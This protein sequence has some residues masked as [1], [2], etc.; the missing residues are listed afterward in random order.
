LRSEPWLIDVKGGKNMLNKVLIANRGEIAVRLVR[1]CHDLGVTAVAL[2]DASDRASLHVRLADECVQLHSALGYMDQAEVLRIARAVGA[3]AIHPGYGFLAEAPEF[4]AAC[5]LAGIA[6]VGPPSTTVAALQDKIATLDRAQDAGF[7]VPRHSPGAFEME[8][9]GRIRAEAERVGYPL[10]VKSYRGGRGRGTRL[11]RSPDRL[12]EAVRRSQTESQA[13][14]GDRQFYLEQAILPSRYVEVSLLCDV[15]GGIVHLGEHDASIQRNNHKIVEESPAPYLD[16]DQRRH[17]WQHAVT[18]ARLFGCQGACTVEF[19]MDADGQFFFTEIKPRIQ[20]EH[21]LSEMVT[22]IDVAREQIR[23]ADGAPLHIRQ[24]DIIPCGWA[25]H[26]RINA[27]DP[28]N[29]SLPSP[30]Q[31]Q[32]FRLPGG[33]GIRVDTYAYSGCDVPVRYDPLLAKLVVWDEDRAAC[34]RRA[35]RALE[36]FVVGGVQ[37]NLPLVQRILDDPDFVRGEYTTEFC[38][39]PLLAPRASGRDLRDLAVAAAVA[40]ASRNMAF[41]PTTLERLDTGWHRES[42]RLPQ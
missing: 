39:R 24:S 12:A 36:D 33:P 40:Y 21:P 7:R 1:A 3:E 14:F 20:V 34:L 26:C 38:R 17:L 4:I 6:F 18:C 16:A 25:M 27:E 15:H 19:V 35:R 5:E 9:M 11:V 37:T 32:Q 28:W 42:R 23:I 13:V 22:G 29:R 2:Y 30:G 10:V 41:R 8:D 31:L